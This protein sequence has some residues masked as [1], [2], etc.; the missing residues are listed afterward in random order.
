MDDI[1]EFFEY[2]TAKFWI[3]VIIVILIHFIPFGEEY[4]GM[5]LFTAL[6]KETGSIYFLMGMIAVE[7]VIIIVPLIVVQRF[8]RKRL[9]FE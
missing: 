4:V 7:F 8:L 2:K 3:A 9:N 6:F 1:R 5:L